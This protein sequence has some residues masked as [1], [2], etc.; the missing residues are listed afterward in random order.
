[1]DGICFVKRLVRPITLISRDEHRNIH[2][3]DWR[4]EA[5]KGPSVFHYMHNN[6]FIGIIVEAWPSLSPLCSLPA[7]AWPMLRDYFT[8]YKRASQ[9][10]ACRPHQEVAGCRKWIWHAKAISF[11]PD[12]WLGIPDEC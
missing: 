1:M 9:S 2:G 3:S 8:L 11:W 10:E 6:E 7:E 4:R 5:M 12:G